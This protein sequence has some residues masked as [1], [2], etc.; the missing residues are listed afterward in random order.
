VHTDLEC[1]LGIISS[2]DA[3]IPAYKSSASTITNEGTFGAFSGV[4][5]TST[6][7]DTESDDT[8]EKSN[9]EAPSAGTRILKHQMFTF[10]LILPFLF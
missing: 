5:T 7:T 4:N 10:A 6:E 3:L 1:D 8:P 2:G 9:D